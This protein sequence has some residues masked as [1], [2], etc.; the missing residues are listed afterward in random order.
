[1]IKDGF[2]YIEL[3]VVMAIIAILFGI[4]SAG[5]LRL[6]D[7]MRAEQGVNQLA[8]FLKS[9]KNKAK[10]NVIDEA[11]LTSTGPGRDVFT[12]LNKYMLGTR[13]RFDI[14]NHPGIVYKSKCWRELIFNWGSFGTPSHCTTEEEISLVGGI[15]FADPVSNACKYVLFENLTEQIYL[16]PVGQDCSLDIITDIINNPPLRQLSFEPELGNYDI[17]AP[18][19]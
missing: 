10:N 4:G 5:L 16:D 3:L 13:L 14:A 1:M 6:Q 17:L 7:T 12:D 19:P 9:E 15:R 2:S 8:S 18:T 11:I